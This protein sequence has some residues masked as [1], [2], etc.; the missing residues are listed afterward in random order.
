LCFDRE[1]ESGGFARGKWLRIA[2]F[3]TSVFLIINVFPHFSKKKRIE[4]LLHQNLEPTLS[5]L[6]SLELA[7]EF[8]HHFFAYDFGGEGLRPSDSRTYRPGLWRAEFL[9]ERGRD[10]KRIWERAPEITRF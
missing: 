4:Q 2:C 3:L 10:R 9:E 6:W 1:F 8:F 7:F 5:L